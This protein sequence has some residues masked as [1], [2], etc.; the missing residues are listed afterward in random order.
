[1]SQAGLASAARS[2][3]EV[4]SVLVS[5]TDAEAEMASGCVGWT[6][7]DLVAH[8]GSN[9]KEVVD[10]SPPPPEPINL[11]AERLMDALVE[12]RKPWTWAEVRD[13]YLR[14]CD[15]AVAGLAALQ[16][17]PLAST[18]SPIAD[19]GSYELNQL[20]DAFAFDHYCH[21]RIDLLAPHGPL[22]RN[23]PEADDALVGPAV[24]WMMTGLPK[25][26]PGLAESLT[27]SIVLRLTGPGGGSFTLKRDGGEIVVHA[28]ALRDPD[29]VV[30][31]T[32]HDFVV[33]GTTR[34]PW[35]N[36]CTIEGSNEVTETFLDAL[37]II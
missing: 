28:G 29:A 11:P 3:A 26:Q 1:M 34:A 6:V 16:E 14:Y 15:G 27:G 4:K 22:E 24:G 7:K 17:E 19:L 18:V 37:N 36:H 12:P 2:V 31:S 23:V 30:I 35:R 9:F 5:I 20:A 13:E 10:P 25:M 21:L 32:A 33:W 8:M